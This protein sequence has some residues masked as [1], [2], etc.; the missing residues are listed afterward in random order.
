MITEPA[1]DA[2]VGENSSRELPRVQ[3]SAIPFFPYLAKW[4]P[5][6][7]VVLLIPVYARYLVQPAIGYYHDDGIYVVNALSLASGHGFR[8]IS[9]PSELFQTKYPVLYPAILALVWK[10]FPAFP[11]NVIGFKL[12]SLL[13]GA[14]WA[15]AVYLLI[16]R[17]TGNGLLARWVAVL[18]LVSPWVIFLSTSVLPDTLFAFLTTASL[19]A[20]SI[21]GSSIRTHSLQIAIA[22]ILASAAFLTRSAGIALIVCACLLFLFRKQ[23][24]DALLFFVV[25]ALAIGPWIVWQTSH[26]ASSGLIEA[27]Y[28]KLS[29][30]SGHIFHYGLWKGVRVVLTNALIIL[31]TA[32]PIAGGEFNGAAVPLNLLAGI[33]AL[34]GF[35]KLL[36][37][38]RFSMP[39]LWAVVYC[40][41]LLCWVC[42][43]QRYEIP[44]LPIALLGF[45]EGVYFLINA[46]RR[47][48]DHRGFASSLR[49]SAVGLALFCIALNVRNLR[50]L[51]RLTAA[52]GTP[53]FARIPADD[54]GEM[55]QLTGWIRNHA[56]PGA[57]VAANCDPIFYLFTNR[58]SIRLFKADPF[59]LYYDRSL[60]KLPLGSSQELR[61]HLK[62]HNIS[63][64]VVTPMPWF[65]EQSYFRKLL[66]ALMQSNPS[67]FRVDERLS[68]PRYYILGVD[69]AQL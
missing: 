22:A 67:A 34:I 35:S 28:T 10:I 60:T 6:A 37:K 55:Q 66:A 26:P 54:W 27:Y 44:M 16:R 61:S 8:T 39:L 29:Y 42:P 25:C 5:L 40:A 57:I 49:I 1:L 9:L 36:V 17:E 24:R 11:Q 18:T 48:F 53:A 15:S 43:P 63:Y 33:V 3:G 56:K 30:Q 59:E 58:K 20:L 65:A 23:R 51:V 69:P 19:L 47:R 12:I 50:E 46:L 52:Y 7:I 45:A 2:G 38:C 31:A 64:I 13:A 14:F 21:A 32:C 62:S 68:D 4:A 41:M